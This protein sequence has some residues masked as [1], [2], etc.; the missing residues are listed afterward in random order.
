MTYLEII[1]LIKEK[2]SNFNCIEGNI[3]E[4]N[5]KEEKYA[6]INVFVEK[7]YIYQDTA[8]YILVLSYVDRLLQDKSNKIQIQSDGI[9]YLNEIINKLDLE[10]NYPLEITPFTETFGD[11]CAGVFCRLTITTNNNIGTCNEY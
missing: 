4:I 11:D 5:F 2:S 1:N 3:Y 7:S 8:N 9:I 6:L 10:I